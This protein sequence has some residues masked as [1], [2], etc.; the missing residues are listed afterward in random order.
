MYFFLGEKLRIEKGTPPTY[1]VQQIKM[2]VNQCCFWEED[3]PDST[4]TRPMFRCL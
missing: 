2:G 1:R 4:P 3:E